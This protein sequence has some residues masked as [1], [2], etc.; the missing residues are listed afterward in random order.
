GG[1]I[2]AENVPEK[3]ET[4]LIKKY[5]GSKI[6][7]GPSG[8]GFLVAGHL[9]IGAIGGTGL[10]QLDQGKL[11]TAGSIAVVSTSG[12]MTNEFI[13]AVA[14]AGKRVSFSVSIGGDRFPISS[15]TDV[16]TLAEDDPATNAI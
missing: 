11:A 9:K 15:L 13:T 10:A 7:A 5:G 1:H 4:E 16:L 3:H 14:L 2:F 6:I 8:V 12:G